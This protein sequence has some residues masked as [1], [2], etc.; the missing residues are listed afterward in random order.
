MKQLLKAFVTM[1]CIASGA[2][3][4]PVTILALGDS[5]TAGYGLAD[6]Q[7]GFVPQLEG[8]LQAQGAEVVVLNAGVSG[9]TSAGGAGRVAWSLTDNVDAVI[10]ALGGNDM[11]RGIDPTVLHTN[12]SAILDEITGRDLPALL[13]GTPATGNYGPHYRS[14]FDAVYPDLAQTY[15]VDLFPSFLQGLQDIGD[16]TR[17]VREFLQPDGLHP[18]AQGVGL[19]VA[20]MGPAVLELIPSRP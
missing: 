3:A 18:N 19:I 4:E 7:D 15:G 20:A 11:L 17:V 5:L 14:A 2:Q 9:D 1:V 16:Q 13:V 6:P 10:V 8:W 12:L